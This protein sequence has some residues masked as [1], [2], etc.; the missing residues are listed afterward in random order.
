MN[1]TSDQALHNKERLAYLVDVYK[2]Y[3]VHINSMFNYFIVL[4][5]LIANA[6]IQSLSRQAD[7]SWV[8]S[9]AI[10]I[11]GAV[12]SLVALAIHLRSRQLLEAIE[13]GLVAEEDKLFSGSVGFLNI[14]RVPRKW[15]LRHKIQFPIAYLLFTTA[16]VSM[17]VYAI[18]SAVKPQLVIAVPTSQLQP[19]AIIPHA[20]KPQ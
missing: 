17:G 1:S 9:A 4:A 18:F 16:F 13:S 7:I 10:A 19:Q 15:F 14:Q 3:Q 12:M 20:P 8:V 11:F 6:Y 2:V 5:G